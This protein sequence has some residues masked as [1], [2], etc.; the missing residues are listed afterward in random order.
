MARP[1]GPKRSPGIASPSK[2]AR[3]DLFLAG[4]WDPLIRVAHDCSLP[5]ARKARGVRHEPCYRSEEVGVLRHDRRFRRQGFGAALLTP[6]REDRRTAMSVF[7]PQERERLRT[8]LVS[9]AER[10]SRIRAAAHTGSAAVGREDRWSDIDLALCI[11][12]GAEI[13]GVVADWTSRMYREHGAGAH[14]DVRRGAT[15]LRVFP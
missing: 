5:G 6:A 14:P 2:A 4:G 13:D 9:Q 7:T 3:N 1:I 8:E 11:K 12:D 10:D 15:L